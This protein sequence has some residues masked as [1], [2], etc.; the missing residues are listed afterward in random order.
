[1]G[2]G[3]SPVA[4][5]SWEASTSLPWS[6]A[7]CPGPLVLGM[8]LACSEVVVLA[9]SPGEWGTARRKGLGTGPWSP[10]GREGTGEP[11]RKEAGSGR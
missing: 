6:R 3:H 7:Q 4:Q 11:Q 8:A 2:L 9:R 10:G 1:M 5:T